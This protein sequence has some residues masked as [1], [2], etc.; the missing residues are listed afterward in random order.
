MTFD[1]YLKEFKDEIQTQWGWSDW[2]DV[3]NEILQ[4]DQYMQEVRDNWVN[5]DMSPGEMAEEILKWRAHDKGLDEDFCMGVEGPLGLNQGIPHGG[6]GKGVLPKPLYDPKAKAVPPTEKDDDDTEKNKKEMKKSLKKPVTEAIQIADSLDDYMEEVSGEMVWLF[7][8][9]DVPGRDRDKYYD[10]LEKPEVKKKLEALYDDSVDEESAALEIIKFIDGMSK[11]KKPKLSKNA[12]LYIKKTDGS[13]SR[14]QFVTVG[15][16]MDKFKLIDIANTYT[17]DWTELWTV[18]YEVDDEGY[19][20][21][22]IESKRIPNP[23]LITDS[24]IGESEEKND[25][26]VSESHEDPFEDFLQRVDRFLWKAGYESD[27]IEGYIAEHYNELKEKFEKGIDAEAAIHDIS[28]SIDES[29]LTQEQIERRKERRRLRR[30][31]MKAE[32]EDRKAIEALKVENAE[33]MNEVDGALSQ[34]LKWGGFRHT[35]S[36]INNAKDFILLT[37]IGGFQVGHDVSAADLEG[38][39]WGATVTWDTP[40]PRSGKL[41]VTEYFDGTPSKTNYINTYAYKKDG[42]RDAYGIAEAIVRLIK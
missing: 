15:E 10:A 16:S 40:D 12:Q 8:Q 2:S 9:K 37:T 25:K 35:S 4:N 23:K 33:L 28:E 26:P 36:V 34:E 6:P 17:S 19:A 41:R 39:H 24:K 13:E 30:E 38:E 5:D 11:P 7:D 18:R 3:Y 20:V 22:S 1:E 32:E 27:E 29:T 14:L 31:A 42:K 21:R